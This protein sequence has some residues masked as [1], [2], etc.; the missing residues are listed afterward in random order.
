MSCMRC[1]RCQGLLI[2]VPSLVLLSTS[3]YEPSI[4]DDLD[5]DAWQ[6]VNCGEYVDAVILANRGAHPPAVALSC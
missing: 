5:G 6:C 4:S 3:S 2:S 1:A